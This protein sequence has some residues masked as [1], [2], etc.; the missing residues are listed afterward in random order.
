MIRVGRFSEFVGKVVEMHN[1][2]QQEE[3]LFEIWLHRI[4]DRSYTDFVNGLAGSGAAPTGEE[5]AE[6]VFDSR[7]VLDS[8]SLSK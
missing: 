2:E 5:L 8:F 3:K 4:F 1:T 6:I 7:S